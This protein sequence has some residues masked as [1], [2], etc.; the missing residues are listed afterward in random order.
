MYRQDTQLRIDLL[1]SGLIEVPSRLAPEGLRIRQRG[2]GQAR[3]VCQ[4]CQG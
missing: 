2:E 3:Q 1:W 4:R